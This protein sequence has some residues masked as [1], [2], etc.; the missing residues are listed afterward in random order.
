MFGCLSTGVERGQPSALMVE[1]HNHAPTPHY[2]MT[3]T[4]TERMMR[5][6]LGSAY[7]PDIYVENEHYV[8]RKAFRGER[9]MYRKDIFDMLAEIGIAQVKVEPVKFEDDTVKVVQVNGSGEYECR[10]TRVYP[11]TRI[12]E[13]DKGRVF[14]GG[15]GF[16]LKKNQIILVK[17]GVMIL[18]KPRRK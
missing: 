8:K 5:E 2:F 12:V 7:N 18:S 9:R 6:R 15:K 14:A 11:N 10:V 13:T 16:G 4:I 3:Y 1:L 17:D